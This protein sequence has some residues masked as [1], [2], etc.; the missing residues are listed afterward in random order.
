MT[1]SAPRSGRG[2]GPVAGAKL[3]E[4]EL[5]EEEPL[6]PMLAGSGRCSAIKSTGFGRE[7][8]GLDFVHGRVDHSV[9]SSVD[10]RLT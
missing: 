4:D 8:T 7:G 5:L 9:Y 10:V 1:C 3:S 2:E 6:H